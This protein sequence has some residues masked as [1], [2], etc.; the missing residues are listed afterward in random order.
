MLDNILYVKNHSDCLWSAAQLRPV[1]EQLAAQVSRDLAETDPLVLCVMNG[2]LFLTAE[3]LKRVNFPLQL[4]Y[5]HATR[6]HDELQGGQIEWVH[7][8][9]D[10]IK[11]RQVLIV[12]DILDIGI[13]L[14]AIQHACLD[15]GAVDVKSLILAVKQHDRR[16]N[17]VAADYIGVEVEDRYVFGCGMDYKGY[18]RN[19]GGIY[20]LKNK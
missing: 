16:I 17:D 12:D 11:G 15:A 1:Y 5:V 20:A 10:K 6:Y 9:V 3:I 7:F 18:Y 4:N 13:T 8:P 19:L 14:K 2:G